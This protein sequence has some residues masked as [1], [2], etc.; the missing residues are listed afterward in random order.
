MS[1]PTDSFHQNLTRLISDYVKEHREF[2]PKD[3]HSVII[4]NVEKPLIH[5]VLEQTNGNLTQAANI[6]G[7]SRA[8]LRKKSQKRK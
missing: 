6:L 3:L 8:T 1:T 5:A 2:L 7:L 4:E